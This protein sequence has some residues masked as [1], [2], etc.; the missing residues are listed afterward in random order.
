MGEREVHVDPGTIA[1]YA[2][3][4]CPW[5]HVCIYRLHET[6]AALG[7]EDAVAFDIRA[8]PLEIV[9]LRPTPKGILDIEIAALTNVEPGAGWQ[10]WSGRDS[11]Y[12][13]T[14]LPPMEAVYAAKEQGLRASEELDRSLRAAFFARSETVSMRHVILD[15]AA[16]CPAVDADALADAFDSGRGRRAL[17]DDAST[18][19]T[20]VVEGSPHLFLPDGTHEHNP[21]VK[22]H[23][24]GAKGAKELVLDRDDRDVYRDL[25]TRAARQKGA[26]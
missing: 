15:N 7:L 11:A 22:L 1:V 14:M 13:V 16:L 6:R 17:M 4:G 19:L 3:I 5:A 24:A 18:S 21:G 10:P 26:A 2:D 9:N 8:F 25:L 12:P 20:D 23:W